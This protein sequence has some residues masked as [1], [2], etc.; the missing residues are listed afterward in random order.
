MVVEN[1]VNPKKKSEIHETIKPALGLRGHF[2]LKPQGTADFAATDLSL[3]RQNPGRN[4]A[5][6]KG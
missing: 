5:E 2:E 1:E 6:H 3:I 4:S